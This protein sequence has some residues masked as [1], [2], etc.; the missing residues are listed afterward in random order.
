MSHRNF[1]AALAH[2]L[3]LHGLIQ[4]GLP[5]T[6]LD[7]IAAA[8]DL[9]VET[10]AGLCGLSRATF[11]RKKAARARLGQFESDMLARYATLLKH[12]T[13]VFEDAAAAGEWLRTAQVGLGGQVPIQLAQTTQ[14]YQ[15]VE[16]LLTRIDYGVYA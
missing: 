14:G 15:E 12:G 9:K 6:L 7:H 3:Q 1:T 4:K 16:K 10:V 2:P 8:L 11:H 5:V 13:E